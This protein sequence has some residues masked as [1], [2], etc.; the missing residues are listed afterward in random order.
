VR[1]YFPALTLILIA[2]LVAEV[3]P[4]SAPISRPA[5]LP[6]IVL[7]YGPGALLIRDVVRSNGRGWVSILVLG[8]AYGVMEEGI[9]LQSLFN[10]DLYN[11]S[12]WGRLGPV[13]AVYA[14]A[15]IP[16]HAIWSAAVPILLV[17]LLFPDGRDR[18]YLGQLGQVVT[19]CW[20]AVG[21]ALLGLLT[22]YSIAPQFR[23]APVLIVWSAIVAVSLIMLAFRLPRIVTRR[24]H[25]TVPAPWAILLLTTGAGSMWHM[26]I[27]ALWRIEPEFA[28]WPL[29]LLPMTS[30]I[31]LLA[32]AWQWLRNWSA[33]RAWN[34]RHWLALAAGSVI[35]HSVFGAV[36]F[37]Q[38][39]ADRA[40]IAV[41]GSALL[42]LI[43]RLT[44]GPK[45][46]RPPVSNR[47]TETV[48]PK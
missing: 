36:I 12:A 23:A 18:P 7:I 2:P 45:P 43:T 44:V 22:R 19:G 6:F 5:L 13:N 47:I 17:D 4:G 35:A 30:A 46:S 40:G 48:P 3:L 32:V 31:A 37:S 10:P 29:A 21:V 20:Y 25:R 24:V 39:F 15:V 28:R 14:V 9:A 11:A 26:L 34:D 38:T 16:I 1:R 27:A 41:L 8:A 33:A 42:L